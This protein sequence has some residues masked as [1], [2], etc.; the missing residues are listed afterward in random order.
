MARLPRARPRLADQFLWFMMALTTVLWATRSDVHWF[1]LPH[2]MT[3]LVGV[4]IVVASEWRPIDLGRGHVSL[5]VAGYLAV[6]LVAGL[7]EALWVV[8]FGTIIGWIRQGFRGL[9]TVATLALMALSLDI[10]AAVYRTTAHPVVGV[11]LFAVVFLAVNH[12]LVQLYYW[13]REGR[14]DRYEILRSLGWDSLGWS[15]SLPLVGIYVL[16]HRVYRDWW[17]GLLALMIYGSLSLL[18][19]FYYQSRVIHA[20]NRRVAKATEGIAAATDKEQLAVSVRDGFRDVVGFTTF[21]LYLKDPATKLLVRDLAVH[22]DAVPYPDIFEVDGAGLTSWAVVTHLPEFITDSREH[23]S[24]TPAPTDSHPIVSGFILPL[25][26]D[27]VVHGLIAMGH[28]YPNGYRPYDF[29]LAKVLA[30]H[31]AMAYRKWVLQ[32]EALLLSRMDPL[33]DHVYN[34]RYFREVLDARIARDARSPMALA[35]LDMDNFKAVN[36]RFGHLAGDTVLQQFVGLVSAELRERDV[37]A[38]YG[39][40]EFVVLLDN[41]DESGAA[42]ALGR[43]QDRLSGASWIDGDVVLGVSAGFALYPADGETAEG[44]LNTADLRMYENKLRRKSKG[45]ILSS[46]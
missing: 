46:G 14:L 3:L 44:L 32:Q 33:L 8:V 1:S 42:Q 45:Q 43:I 19:T 24:A 23:L 12:G 28:D 30:Q 35:L 2:H 38:R 13:I 17:V 29:D 11:F 15:I 4:L 21:V 9:R 16:L 5:S 10:S 41:V 34:F 18:L 40:D 6:F 36:D 37:L 22:P 39:G 20:A 7:T 27:R 31:A 25:V 26:V